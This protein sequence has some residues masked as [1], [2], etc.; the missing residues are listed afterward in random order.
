LPQITAVGRV[1]PLS[2]MARRL[3]RPNAIVAGP[4]ADGLAAPRG[5]SGQRLVNAT[6]ARLHAVV[7]RGRLHDDREIAMA[8]VEQMRGEPSEGRAVV[9]AD[10]A[11]RTV[12]AVGVGDDIGHPMQ[13]EQFEDFR[14][15]GFTDQRHRFDAA[16]QHRT[17]LRERLR[18]I[19]I[20]AAQE[21]RDAVLGH[22]R[23]HAG[24][25]GREHLVVER[26]DDRAR[27]VGARG[28]E[29]A[30]GRVGDPVQ[31]ARRV[32]HA[33]HVGRHLAGI[34]VR[35]T[36]AVDTPASFATSPSTERPLP[37]RARARRRRKRACSS[38]ARG[39]RRGAMCRWS[40]VPSFTSVRRGRACISR[41]ACENVSAI[42]MPARIMSDTSSNR[43]TANFSSTPACSA[44]LSVANVSGYI[45]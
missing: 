12:V 31:R 5:A 2:A 22:D 33:L 41:A 23:L 6:Q 44:I 20:R 24:D 10:A 27:N 13:V 42:L 4:R 40:K 36:V 26:R 38:A 32:A 19:V 7:V 45:A 8:E 16:R 17:H 11:M 29:C 25:L 1:G 37:R 34:V 18:R 14:R 21:Q 15:I 3:A 30:T 28:R 43:I 35:E 9:E 39:R